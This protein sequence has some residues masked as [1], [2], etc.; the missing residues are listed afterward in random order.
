MGPETPKP[1]CALSEGER[2]TAFVELAR[3][4]R[5]RYR[6]KEIDMWHL[7]YATWGLCVAVGA[8]VLAPNSPLDHLG[9]TAILVVAIPMLHVWAV[10]KH[11]K[12]IRFWRAWAEYY[13]TQADTILG[14]CPEPD[15]RPDRHRAPALGYL[16]QEWVVLQVLPTSCAGVLLTVLAW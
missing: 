13:A 9:E 15:A 12:S 5:T 14:L 10:W 4:M 2:V 1:S 3:V 16:F 8:A 11:M 7:N 6:E